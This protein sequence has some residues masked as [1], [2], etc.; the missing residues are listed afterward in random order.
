MK[1]L[2]F[3]DKARESKLKTIQKFVNLYQ[4]IGINLI[5]RRGESQMETFA[6]DLGVD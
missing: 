3:I 1:G 2:L 5:F 4:I 6:R